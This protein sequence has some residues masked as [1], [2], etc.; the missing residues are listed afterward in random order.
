MTRNEETPLLVHANRSPS[1]L[2]ATPVVEVTSAGPLS[3]EEEARLKATLP[4]ADS[5]FTPEA[6]LYKAAKR[7]HLVCLFFT[8]ANV[9][10]WSAFFASEKDDEGEVNPFLVA[11]IIV[12]VLYLIE[13]LC[14]PCSGATSR[15]VLNMNPHRADAGEH[16][17][18]EEMRCKP[19]EMMMEIECFHNE[20][21]TRW[22]TEYFTDNDGNRRTKQKRETYTE[23]VVTFRDKRLKKFKSWVDISGLGPRLDEI[24]KK[25]AGV[26]VFLKLNVEPDDGETAVDLEQQKSRF[27]QENKHRDAHYAFSENTSVRGFCSHVLLYEATRLP[28]FL[29][30][31][32]YFGAT[33]LLL[34][35]PFR[36]IFQSHFMETQ[37]FYRKGSPVMDI[38]KPSKTLMSQHLKFQALPKLLRR[39]LILLLLL[40]KKLLLNHR[41]RKVKF[42]L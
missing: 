33:F 29:G 40:F 42:L 36:L 12:Y 16:G 25:Y 31:K 17:I 23:K 20:T 26:L 28:W 39:I 41:L 21:C 4:V 35:F 19:P 7:F 9:A 27:I 30:P 34:S 8:C 22:V 18:F 13:A 6:P 24:D 11:S 10:L 1:V 5:V 2:E 15:F 38:L 32:A 37:F 3:A 14:L